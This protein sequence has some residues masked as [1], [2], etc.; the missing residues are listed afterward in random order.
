MKRK[1]LSR[2]AGFA[3]WLF[4]GIFLWEYAF[5]LME[6]CCEKM[7]NKQEGFIDV[8]DVHRYAMAITV[9]TCIGITL[10]IAVI[11]VVITELWTWMLCV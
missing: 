10:L 6:R 1:D 2:I 8:N 5:V 7:A 3:M 9:G 11:T 4:A